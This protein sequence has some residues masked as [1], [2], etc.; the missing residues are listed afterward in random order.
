ME[1]AYQEA[2]E[3]DKKLQE[4]ILKECEGLVVRKDL[5]FQV[6]NNLAVPTFVLEFLLAQYCA[7]SDEKVVEEG[8]QK[9]KE[10]VINNYVNR[11]ECEIVKSRIRDKGTY[12]VIDKVSAYLHEGANAYFCD[13][14]NLQISGLALD[15]RYVKGNEK[16][17][18][19]AS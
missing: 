7:S 11:A 4:K 5:A 15:E 18:C 1:E 16:L 13:L 2:A 9:V 3:A 10:I 6:K 8:K 14:E 17:P 19:G 12:V